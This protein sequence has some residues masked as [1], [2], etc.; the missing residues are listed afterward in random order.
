MESRQRNAD[1]GRRPS[2]AFCR[3]CPSSVPW[4][5][6]DLGQPLMTVEQR[7]DSLGRVRQQHPGLGHAQQQGLVLGIDRVLSQ[8]E[9]LFSL[10]TEC[11]G[12][13]HTP[14]LRDTNQFLALI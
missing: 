1:E 7:L 2:F 14:T 5:S 13:K 8:T 4:S 3:L 12:T 6:V 11:L 9:A 10:V